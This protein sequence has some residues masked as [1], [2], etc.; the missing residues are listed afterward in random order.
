MSEWDWDIVDMPYG[1]TVYAEEG[2]DIV[3][4]V[5]G[6]DSGTRDARTKIIGAAPD[7]L[8]ALKDSS[9]SI[10]DV[11][12]Y[13]KTALDEGQEIYES[14]WLDKLMIAHGDMLAAIAEAEESES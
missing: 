10:I 4:V 3:A 9:T 2:T 13:L 11:C 1:N 8:A 12:D 7:M 14:A 5:Y 6:S